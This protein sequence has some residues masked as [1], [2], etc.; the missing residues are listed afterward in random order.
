MCVKKCILPRIST[1]LWNQTE[2]QSIHANKLHDRGFYFMTQSLA[3]M[4]PMV[5]VFLKRFLASRKLACQE[6]GK[7]NLHIQLYIVVQFSTTA[8]NSWAH[9]K[10][11]T[12]KLL[13]RSLDYYFQTFEVLNL[14]RIAYI[15]DVRQHLRMFATSSFYAVTKLVVT[16]SGWWWTGKRETLTHTTQESGVFCWKHQQPFFDWL[17]WILQVFKKSIQVVLYKKPSTI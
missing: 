12:L 15:V 5:V 16:I 4:P 13:Q 11:P 1:G 9:T 3:W 2:G 6:A 7:A 17:I 8:H 10:H 14:K